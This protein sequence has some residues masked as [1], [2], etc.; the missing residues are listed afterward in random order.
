MLVGTAVRTI[1]Y[2]KQF[3][4]GEAEERVEHDESDQREPLPRDGA[5]ELH[6]DA[7]ARVLKL[8]L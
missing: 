6:Q 3:Q 4:T 5:P 8:I 1:N 2:C 7:R